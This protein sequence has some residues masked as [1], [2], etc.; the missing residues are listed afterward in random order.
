MADITTLPIMTASD[1]EKIG[2]ARFNDVPTLPID[3]PDGNFTISARTSDGRRITFF[4]GENRRGSPAG[5]V[6]IQYQDSGATVPN[7]NGCRSPIFDMLTIARQGRHP[8]D[9][10]LTPADRPSIAV[11][12]REPLAEPARRK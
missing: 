4:F 1:V 3:V 8:Y 11:I 12:L 9:T 6:D 5:F 7:A 2:F 10:R